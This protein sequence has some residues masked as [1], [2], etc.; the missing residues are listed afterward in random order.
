MVGA[1]GILGKRISFMLLLAIMGLALGWF[2]LSSENHAFLILMFTVVKHTLHQIFC[3]K[4]FKCTV[5]WHGVRLH[6]CATIGFQSF[7]SS[8]TESL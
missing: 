3:F 2:K 7:S 6:C 4:S 8:Q 5:Q 1:D